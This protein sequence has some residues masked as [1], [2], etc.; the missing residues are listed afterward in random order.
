MRWF[1]WTLLLFLLHVPLLASMK[2]RRYWTSCADWDETFP[3]KHDDFCNNDFGDK[4]WRHVD[5]AAKDCM[6]GQGKGL[7]EKTYSYTTKTLTF[8]FLTSSGIKNSEIW[9]HFF[10]QNPK[11]IPYSVYVHATEEYKEPKGFPAPPIQVRTVSSSW[12]EDLVSPMNALLD[13][14]VLDNSKSNMLSFYIF[15]SHDT[16]PIVSLS[17]MFDYYFHRGGS[18]PKSHFCFSSVFVDVAH[19]KHQQWLA[20]SHRDAIVVNNYVQDNSGQKPIVTAHESFRDRIGGSPEFGCIDEYWHHIVVSGAQNLSRF[21]T[22]QQHFHRY[23]SC[24]TWVNWGLTGG[25]SL[26]HLIAGDT[27]KQM[28]FD[29]WDAKIFLFAPVGVF[30]AFHRDILFVRKIRRYTKVVL[31]NGTA[32]P[33]LAAVKTLGLYER[34]SEQCRSGKRW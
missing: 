18:V 9:A 2:H 26:I 24:N 34:K 5:Q 10:R 14:A 11:K 19:A 15:V 6:P 28:M 32:V 30:D 25:F 17:C 22:W 20:L 8:L 7:C 1:S 27:Y 4:G 13:A 3:G 12:C 16:I 33:V 31:E 23:H 29:D 21:A